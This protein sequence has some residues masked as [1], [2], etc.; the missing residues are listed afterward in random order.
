MDEQRESHMEQAVQ[1]EV[2]PLLEA[3]A[4]GDDAAL[5]KLFPLVYQELRALAHRQRRRLQGDDTLNTTALVHEAY[6]KLV[7]HSRVN[8][9]S[10]AHFFA[11][12]AKAMRHILMNYAR[13]RRVQKRGGDQ[14][15][16]SLEE[17]GER[18]EGE[19]ALSDD[20]ADLL[21]ALEAALENLERANERQ[22]RIVECRYFGGMTIQETA[23]A[24]GI[25]TASVSR[26]WALAQVRLYQDMKA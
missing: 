21:L 24:L 12:A 17:L 2:T 25:S 3:L 22:S 1:A 23:A 11:T 5:D 16:F 18:L 15:K 14:P 8:W 6:L 26:G 20:N 13:D 10:R 9:E 4:R 7:D 19:L